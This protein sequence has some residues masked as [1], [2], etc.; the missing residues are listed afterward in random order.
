MSGMADTITDPHTKSINRLKAL[1]IENTAKHKNIKSLG[2]DGFIDPYYENNATDFVAIGDSGDVQQ[3]QIVGMSDSVRSLEDNIIEFTKKNISIAEVDDFLQKQQIAI[4]PTVQEKIVV[5]PED[6][7]TKYSGEID[8]IA[9]DHGLI[10][11]V[12]EISENSTIWKAEGKHSEPDLNRLLQRSDDGP[13]KLRDV[14]CDFC[15]VARRSS[16]EVRLFRFA[17]RLI[18]YSYNRQK[19]SISLHSI[20]DIMVDPENGINILGHLPEEERTEI[21]NRCM[22][23]MRHRFDLMSESSD[24]LHEFEWQ[25]SSF[26]NYASRRANMLD[27]IREEL[28][29]GEEA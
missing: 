7:Y 17:E 24:Q 5:L 25:Q 1:Y 9:K 15:T 4:T 16:E 12:I 10:V 2:Y 21:W 3:I 14:N 13:I 20:D 22:W 26:L 8:D 29:I 6:L 28:D 19:E 23:H 18:S 11:W 27:K